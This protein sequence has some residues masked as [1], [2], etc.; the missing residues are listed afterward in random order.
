M[1]V[2][3]KLEKKKEEKEEERDGEKGENAKGSTCSVEAARA[4]AVCDVPLSPLLL[5]LR[6]SGNQAGA[7]LFDA[8]TRMHFTLEKTR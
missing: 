2:V 7:V 4:T 1:S 6:R 5:L 8:H 3:A